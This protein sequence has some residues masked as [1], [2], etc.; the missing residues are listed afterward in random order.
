MIPSPAEAA[1]R[2]LILPLAGCPCIFADQDAPRPP[3]PYIALRTLSAI[4]PENEH[5]LQVD[6]NGGQA[7]KSHLDMTIEIQAFGPGWLTLLGDLRQKLKWETTSDAC[8]RAGL[9]IFDRGAVQ[10][11]GSLLDA[12]F[13]EPRGCLEIG[14]RTLQ[15]TI[16]QVGLIETVN[17]TGTLSGSSTP[18]LDASLSVV[19]PP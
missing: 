5:Y 15:E 6:A 8:Y 11:I 3:H 12:A 16:D 9:A 19:A 17:V 18:V 10:D 1:I 14:V 13:W 4:G 7:V 2:A